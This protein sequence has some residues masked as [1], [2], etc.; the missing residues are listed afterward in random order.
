MSEQPASPDD[1][2]QDRADHETSPAW[3]SQEG[4]NQSPKA[5][6]AQP[7]IRPRETVEQRYLRQTRNATVLVAIMATI[8]FVLGIIG[9][10][11][12][13]AQLAR[14]NCLTSQ[15]SSQYSSC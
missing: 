2:A 15:G 12:V 3:Y 7:G 9:T 4:L 1:S 8:V 10:I 5:A 13:G 6:T 11:V 14:L